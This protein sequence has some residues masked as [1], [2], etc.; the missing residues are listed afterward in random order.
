MLLEPSYGILANLILNRA[1]LVERGALH[2][3]HRDIVVNNSPANAGDMVWSL[4]WKDPTGAGKWQPTPVF[5]PGK[6][7]G[8]RSLAHYQ[9]MGLQRVRYNWAT[10]H[11]H[12]I[13]DLGT[14]VQERP[15]P[16]WFFLQNLSWLVGHLS[17]T[18]ST[19]TSLSLACWSPLLLLLLISAAAKSLQ[20]CRTLCNPIDGS[21][22]GSPVPGILKAR[23]LEWVAISFSNAWKWKVKVK[24]L[25]RI[26]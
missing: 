5:L 23:T 16:T 3:H 8:Q 11:A 1:T 25:S 4:D 24:S 17:L 18:N 12:S 10:E 19:P 15:A 6:F 21:P 22:P 14:S 7:H 26:S 13:K 20:S 2:L 9:S